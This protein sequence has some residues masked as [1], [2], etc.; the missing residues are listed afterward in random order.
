VSS[1]GLRRILIACLAVPGTL[2][3]QS[4]GTGLRPGLWEMQ[5]VKQVVDGRDVSAQVSA[6][7]QQMQQAMANMPPAE[8]AR[9]QAMLSAHGM[10]AGA[11]GYRICVTPQMA[12]RSSPIIDKSGRCQKSKLTHSGNRTTFAFTCTENGSTTTGNGV[13]TITRELVTT[14]TRATTVNSRGEKHTMQ[15][16]SKMRYLRSDCGNVKPIPEEK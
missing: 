14:R 1:A 10:S 6:A 7:S 11:H 15:V 5:I 12:K 8:R 4:A 3:A 13:A 9:M 2:F 16:E